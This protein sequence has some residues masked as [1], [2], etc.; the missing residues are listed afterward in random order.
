M[1]ADTQLL[2]GD[3]RQMTVSSANAASSGSGGPGHSVASRVM[4][5]LQA[6]NYQ[7]TMECQER[8]RET[9]LLNTMTRFAELAAKQVADKEPAGALQDETPPVP[10]EV[11]SLLK[12]DGARTRQKQRRATKSTT[13]LWRRTMT[14]STSAMV[15]VTAG[16]GLGMAGAPRAVRGPATASTAPAR[17]APDAA[18]ASSTVARAASRGVAPASTAARAAL[19]GV[20][21]ASRATKAAIRGVSPA[22]RG[23]RAASGGLAPA[24]TAARAARGSVAGAISAGAGVARAISAGAAP[25]VTGAS[26]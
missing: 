13:R 8:I 1:L 25:P 23:G 14:A 3:R 24:S 15:A 4:D 2:P 20:A 17:A 18:P 21:P 10:E 26:G 12:R 5:I 16:L 19:P 11:R 9:S 22:R 6:H 7:R